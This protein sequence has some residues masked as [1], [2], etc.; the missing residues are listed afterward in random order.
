MRTLALALILLA[1]PV[2]AEEPQY[3]EVTADADVSIESGAN[4]ATAGVKYTLSFGGIDRQDEVIP[5]LRRFV[6]H[7]SA[8]WVRIDRRGSSAVESETSVNVGGILHLFDGALHLSGE[9]G[10][11]RNDVLFDDFYGGEDYYDTATYHLELGGRPLPLLSIGAFFE[12]EPII[13]RSS[14]TDVASEANTRDGGAKT[15]GGVVELSTPD[16]RLYLHL[17][18][19]YHTV[20]WTFSGFHPGD[21]TIRGIGGSLQATYQLD[22]DAG[23]GLRTTMSREHWVDTRMGDN[24]PLWLGR[25]LDRQV[26][27]VEIDA[28]FTFWYRS[29]FGFRVFLGGG[30]QE[31]PP[32][33]AVT[34]TGFGKFGGGITAR[35]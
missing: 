31:A 19:F 26:W 33:I 7:P 21:I 24:D 11:S 22:V 10:V 28:E 4:T 17:T 2:L 15:I 27:N 14:G 23:V 16:D 8:V 12:G 5:A 1:S 20:D 13:G 25:N 3:H 29:R 35:F 30:Y 18:G 6:R 34:A 32:L 9:A